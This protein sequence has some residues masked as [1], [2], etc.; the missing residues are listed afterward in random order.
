MSWTLCN[1]NRQWLLLALS[2]D[3][4]KLVAGVFGGQ[5]HTTVQSDRIT[6][7]TAGFVI[8]THGDALELLRADSGLFVPQSH[9]LSADLFTTS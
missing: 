2:A 8:G 1:S 7:G 4:S 9:H 6:A 5:L 3:G